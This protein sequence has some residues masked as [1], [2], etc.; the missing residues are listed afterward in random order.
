MDEALGKRAP[1]RSGLANCPKKC[2]LPHQN[3]INIQNAFWF[4]INEKRKDVIGLQRIIDTQKVKV[5]INHN[6]GKQLVITIIE[7]LALIIFIIYMYI[8][9]IK[10]YD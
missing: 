10:K 3:G 7:L 9:V 8:F 1:F 6:T 4:K 2:R 5:K